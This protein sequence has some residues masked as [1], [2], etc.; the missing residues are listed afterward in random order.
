M[1][2]REDLGDQVAASARIK[3][4]GLQEACSQASNH[5]TGALGRIFISCKLE[6]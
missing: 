6:A 4:R 1:F 3:S 2:R 5:R